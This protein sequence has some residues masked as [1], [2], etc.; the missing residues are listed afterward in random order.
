[1]TSLSD[2]DSHEPQ[3]EFDSPFLNETVFTNEAATR[4]SQVWEARYSS[5]NKIQSPFLD[6]S[7][8]WQEQLGEPQGDEMLSD[9]L[10][11]AFDEELEDDKILSADLEEANETDLE[12]ELAWEQ[13]Y[14]IETEELNKKVNGEGFL[15]ELDIGR[16]GSTES[17]EI[18]N[19]F[20][21]ETWNDDQWEV[22]VSDDES[23]SDS[24]RGDEV[25]EN[26]SLDGR[27]IALSNQVNELRRRQRRS[28]ERGWEEANPSGRATQFSNRGLKGIVLW[29]FAVDDGE[30]KPE[31]RNEL[32][33]WLRRYASNLIEDRKRINVVGHA[34]SPGRENDNLRLSRKRSDNV[35]SFIFRHPSFQPTSDNFDPRTLFVGRM[36]GSSTSGAMSRLAREITLSRL[37]PMEN[38]AFNRSVIVAQDLPCNPPL[39]D[40]EIRRIAQ[41]YLRRRF[42]SDFLDVDS[43]WTPTASTMHRMIPTGFSPFIHTAPRDFGTSVPPVGFTYRGYRSIKS[44]NPEAEILHLV[45]YLLSIYHCSSETI[46]ERINTFEQIG[47]LAISESNRRIRILIAGMFNRTPG[48]TRFEYLYRSMKSD[49]SCLLH[50]L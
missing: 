23:W 18:E 24:N 2:S 30:M 36:N 16:I 7:E 22:E 29:N 4:A 35:L 31:H 48:F 25:S 28:P 44:F 12:P 38:L 47:R 13:P 45:P 17:S 11:K 19:Y 10:K 49:Q 26:E 46:I 40:S 9:D 1:M 21:N 50:Y 27:E 33:E 14:R 34:S 41:S 5:F 32:D 20:D 6:E 37:T 43:L 42:R 39:S 3:H 8:L 15:E